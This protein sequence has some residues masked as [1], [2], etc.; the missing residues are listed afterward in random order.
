SRR[1]SAERPTLGLDCF[2][3][4][5][6]HMEST[7]CKLTAQRAPRIFLTLMLLNLL[8]CV[9]VAAEDLSA[10][11]KKAIENSTLDQPGTRPYHLQ[12]SFAPSQERDKV[13]NRVGEVEIW[14]QAPNKWRR[15]LRSPEFH[16]VA[17]QNGDHRWEKNEGDFFPDWL[18]ELVV[19]IVQPVPLSMDVL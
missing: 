16:Q 6:P 12:A 9:H 3:Y 4:Q 18:R 10:Q 1:L 13:T 14:W 15:E 7:H 11:V 17:I 19:A 5:G 2:S 8:C